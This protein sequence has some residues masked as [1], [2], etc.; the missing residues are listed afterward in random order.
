MSFLMLTRKKSQQQFWW[1]IQNV[2]LMLTR[3]KSQQQFFIVFTLT[4]LGI[5]PQFTASIANSISTL[6]PL[7]CLILV[8]CT[9][10]TVY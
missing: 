9:V 5:E 8:R 6:L 10:F 2:V 4:R 1:R 7:I 3:K